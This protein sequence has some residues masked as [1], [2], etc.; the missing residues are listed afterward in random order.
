MTLSLVTSASP[1]RAAPQR[2]VPPAHPC[3][4]LTKT[5]PLLLLSGFIVVDLPPEEGAGFIQTL[6]SNGLAFVPLISPT[7]TDE[8]M[9]YLASAASSFIYCVSVT[10][11]TGSR[12]SVSSDLVDFVGRIRKQTA[13]PLAVGFGIGTE[14]QVRKVASLSDGVVVGSALLNAMGQVPSSAPAAERA[15]VLK[16]FVSQLKSGA[17]GQPS[18]AR[19]VLVSAKPTFSLPDTS[20]SHFGQFG[21]RFIPETLAEAHEELEVAYAEAQADPSF[22]EGIAYYRR[23]FVGGPTP[24]YLAR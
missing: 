2:D 19:S 10:G 23:V 6:Q 9:K 16:E 3:Q 8:R 4:P 1:T 5:P 14:S 18:S 21:G 12:A 17:K 20:K 13:L 11:V 15:L 24:V 7:T 22:H